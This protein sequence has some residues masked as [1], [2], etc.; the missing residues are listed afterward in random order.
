MPID[1]LL[2]ALE[3]EA[4][5]S[6]DQ[7]TAEA[8]HEA[9]AIV[10][11]GQAELAERRRSAR[12]AA[13]VRARAAA[14]LTLAQATRDGRRD[15]LLA[16]ERLLDRV[17]AAAERLLPGAIERQDY[18]ATLAARVA[19]ASRCIGENAGTLGCP[20]ALEQPL[21]RIAAGLPGLAV[22]LDAGVG[23]GFVLNSSD[24]TITVEDTLEARLR[25]DHAALA[26]VALQAVAAPR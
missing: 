7:I 3:R 15:V 9:D 12:Q 10:A 8:R 5:A 20:P 22:A 11:A 26:R 4:R 25:R 23:A 6:A 18:L 13:E 14:D 1:Q 2:A 17:F 24:G 21:Q 19:D 16:R